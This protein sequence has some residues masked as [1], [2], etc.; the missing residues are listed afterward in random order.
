[1]KSN[2]KT[3]SH[4][5][6]AVVAITLLTVG[7]LCVAIAIIVQNN[8]KKYYNIV[9]TS[10][11]SYNVRL[12]ENDF[13]DTELEMNKSY[14]SSLISTIDT[15][16]VYVFDGNEPARIDY[17]YQIDAK[18]VGTY[19]STDTGKSEVWS[20]QY[21]ILNNTKESLENTKEFTVSKAFAIDYQ[22]YSGIV[23]DFKQSL[24]LA[25]DADLTIVMTVNYKGTILASGKTFDGSK[26]IQ[27][28]M[29]V[30][31]AVTKLTTTFTPE[32]TRTVDYLDKINAPLLAA[33]IASLV[34]SFIIS[35]FIFNAKYRKNAKTAY[36]KD[37]N[38][39][40]KNYGEILVEAEKVP[41][42][43]GK[44]IVDIT[45]FEDLVDTEEELRSPIIY[46]EVDEGYETWFMITTTDYI[47]R[48]IL[49]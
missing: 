29:P 47:Y 48:F 2:N 22:K 20:R 14:P 24:K 31:K 30:S 1:M 4:I 32:T 39:I 43:K 8:S 9:E 19:E 10:D 12:S 38:T 26:T 23:N 44:Q 6:L 27:I 33:G 17:N 18:I 7:I 16:L 13:Y 25:I 11:V 5:L 35:C 3:K 40:L 41:K 46:V 28:S 49:K 45:N 15:N 21:A 36:S 34:N 42:T 37:L